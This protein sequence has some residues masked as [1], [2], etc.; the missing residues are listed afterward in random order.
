MRRGIQETENTLGLTGGETEVIGR[1]K[2]ATMKYEQ[3]LVQ[4]TVPTQEHSCARGNTLSRSMLHLRHLN[5]HVSL[6]AL[7]T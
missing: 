6:P 1:R 7:P 2:K 5:T 3:H 4:Y